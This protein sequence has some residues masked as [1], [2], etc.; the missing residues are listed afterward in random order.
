MRAFGHSL[1]DGRPDTAVPEADLREF[2]P[3]R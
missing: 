1:E 2:G 3:L